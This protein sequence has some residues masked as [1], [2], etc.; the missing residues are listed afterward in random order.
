MSSNTKKNHPYVKKENK[1]KTE[2]KNKLKGTIFI[3]ALP[4]Y[5]PDFREHRIPPKSKPAKSKP[6]LK[7]LSKLVETIKT[8]STTEKTEVEVLEE[9]EIPQDSGTGTYQYSSLDE[10]LDSV[11]VSYPC[12]IHQSMMDVLKSK[13][14]DCDDVFLR[15]SSARCPIFCNLSDYNRYYYECQRQGH[16]WFTLDR[17][18]KMVCECGMTP[19]LSLT[20]SE[21]NYGKMYLRCSRHNCDLFT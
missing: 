11:E 8:E 12:P 9:G 21:T 17:I 6:P 19:T 3:D 2:A 1:K 14:E 7:E 18:D 5:D 4:M 13:K 20:Q 10:L 16:P 15:C